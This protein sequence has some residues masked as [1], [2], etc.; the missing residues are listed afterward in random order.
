MFAEGYLW[1]RFY[2]LCHDVFCTRN[3]S[4][5]PPEERTQSGA[6]TASESARFRSASAPEAE[7]KSDLK[8]VWFE[9]YLPFCSLH[10]VTLAYPQDKWRANCSTSYG[11]CLK[12]VED[13]ALEDAR[14]YNGWS[15]YAKAVEMYDCDTHTTAGEV[16][17]EE[18]TSTEMAPTTEATHWAITTTLSASNAAAL[19]QC[20]VVY[21]MSDPPTTPNATTGDGLSDHRGD[22]SNHL[23]VCNDCKVRN[24][25]QTSLCKLRDFNLDAQIYL[26]VRGTFLRIT[27]N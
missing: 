5:L 4:L 15:G 25:F 19:N 12:C 22:W 16:T 1:E 27:L 17:P 23:Y 3:H 9:L 8:D 14:A 2:Y 21:N 11:G 10:H 26:D 24:Q 20:A 6:S 18:S 13:V 7:A